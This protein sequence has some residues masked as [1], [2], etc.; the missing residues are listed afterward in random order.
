[1]SL[2]YEIPTLKQEAE[3]LKT[4]QANSLCLWLKNLWVAYSKFFTKSSWYPKYKKKQNNQ[5]VSYR[6][7]IH[8]KWSHIQIPKVWLVSA[9]IH[10]ECLWKI[11]M[12]TIEKTASWKYYVSILTDYEIEKPTTNGQVWV[13]VWL[14]TFA[15]CSDWQEFDN[16]KFLKKT[17]KK[18]KKQQRRLS[19]KQKG[20]NNRDK[21]RLVV[22]R[23]H[24]KVSN[25]R[26]DFLHKVSSSIASEYWLVAMEKL[27][28]KGMQKNHRL[29]QAISDVGWYKFKTFLQYKTNVIE[30]G[31]FQPS[32]KKCLKCWNIKSDLTL[33]DRMYNC[34]NCG[35]SEDRDLMASKNIL[36]MAIS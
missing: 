17:Q 34:D 16:P 24:E 30:I 22:A 6:Q 27:N 4:S 19:R 28:V 1:M 14:K 8:I 20:S 10:R 25:Q 9:V 29:A 36:A 18:L 23:L 2:S 7:N 5:T 21:Q 33:K 31:T 11:K 32:S 3:W 12:A 35:Y 13:D 26:Q 15:V